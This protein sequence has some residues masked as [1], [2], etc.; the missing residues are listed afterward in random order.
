[1]CVSI[2]IKQE[3]MNAS[4]ECKCSGWEVSVEY[5]YLEKDSQEKSPKLRY[6]NW[7]FSEEAHTSV[8]TLWHFKMLSRETVTAAV[9]GD[10][11]GF[12]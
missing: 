2:C 1:M 8:F 10:S 9:Q 12:S 6:K 11:S 4:D 5:I 7:D 3:Q